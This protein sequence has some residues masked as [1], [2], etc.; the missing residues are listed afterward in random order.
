[1]KKAADGTQVEDV[2]VDNEEIQDVE[3][4]ETTDAE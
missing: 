1:M 4:V 2:D 3:I